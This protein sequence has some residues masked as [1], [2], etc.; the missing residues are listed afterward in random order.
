MNAVCLLRHY[1]SISMVQLRS[2]IFRQTIQKFT[3]CSSAIGKDFL[4]YDGKDASKYA[5]ANCAARIALRG[6][7]NDTLSRGKVYCFSLKSYYLERCSVTALLR[8]TQKNQPPFRIKVLYTPKTFAITTSPC[9][10]P[11]WSH[12]RN[13]QI[14]RITDHRQKRQHMHPPPVDAVA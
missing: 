6:L 3:G 10:F 8:K 11:V 14:L 13:I 7:R 9:A 1:R 2:R 12:T 4:K 5:Y